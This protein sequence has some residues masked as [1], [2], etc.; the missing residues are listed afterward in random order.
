MYFRI[1]LFILVSVFAAQN[2]LCQ[3]NP[4][5]PLTEDKERDFGVLIGLGM[6]FQTGDFYTIK[7]V[8]VYFLMEVNLVILL[9]LS[10]R[11]SLRIL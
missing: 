2:I 10:I 4:L 5:T 3:S 6:N 1:I 11:K 7:T 9:V 8:S